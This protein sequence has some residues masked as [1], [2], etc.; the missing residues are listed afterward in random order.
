MVLRNH[1][2]RRQPINSIIH[3]HLSQQQDNIK[4]SPEEEQYVI[5]NATIHHQLNAVMNPETGDLQEL[6]QL[7]K[8]PDGPQWTEGSYT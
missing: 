3:T 6:R 8:G 1:K 7:L 4:L 2:Q 5:N